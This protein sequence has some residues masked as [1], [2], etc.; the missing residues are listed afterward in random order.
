TKNLLPRIPNVQP[1]KFLSSHKE[2]WT[3]D[4]SPLDGYLS[5]TPQ[6]IDTPTG[7]TQW[8]DPRGPAP[9]APP[10]GYGGGYAPPSGP[11]QQG[12]GQPYPPQPGYPQPYQQ[13]PP[14]QPY[15]YQQ[16]QPP[17]QQ[18]PAGY[19]Q[20]QQPPY[21]QPLPQGYAP[22]GTAGYNPTPQ[23]Y[24]P[25]TAPH[26]Q[27]AKSGPGWGGVA[28]AGAAGLIGGAIIGDLVGKNSAHHD[29]HS[30]G[31]FVAPVGH[32]GGPKYKYKSGGFFGGPKYKYKGG[33]RGGPKY[34]YKGG[35]GG[36]YG[37]NSGPVIIEQPIFRE[38]V[39]IEEPV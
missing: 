16:Q 5:G 39:V 37:Y 19:P 13:Q 24:T 4:L 17:P 30:G 20:N 33:Y 9:A 11:P 32:F 26:S 8:D 27:P 34:K 2:K 14:Q 36:G 31:G 29:H 10:P 3:I 38:T 1:Q 28:A 21:Q 22:G 6:E 12:Y 25:T 35:Y 15:G 18:Y 23:S 7:I